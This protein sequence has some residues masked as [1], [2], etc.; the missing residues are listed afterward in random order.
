MS[1]EKLFNLY[2]TLRAIP[3]LGD[4]LENILVLSSGKCGMFVICFFKSVSCYSTLEHKMSTT[5]RQWPAIARTYLQVLSTT[6]VSSCALFLQLV[7]S[8]HL[9]HCPWEICLLVYPIYS[10]IISVVKMSPFQN[11]INFKADGGAPHGI[12]SKTS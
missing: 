9:L 3:F 11:Y 6:S 5:K 2:I 4:E 12:L 8:L 1:I 7:R 10:F